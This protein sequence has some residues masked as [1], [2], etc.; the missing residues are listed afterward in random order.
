MS[1]PTA[2]LWS[3]QVREPL[4]ARTWGNKRIQEPQSGQTAKRHAGARA[5][6]PANSSGMRLWCAAVINRAVD[7]LSSDTDSP[8]LPHHR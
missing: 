5:T 3:V 8:S 1:K 4:G 7:C 2:L 6:G